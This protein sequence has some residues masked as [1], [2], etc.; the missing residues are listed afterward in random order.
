VGQLARPFVWIITDYKQAP[1]KRQQK[2]SHWA[3]GQAIDTAFQNGHFEL[4]HASLVAAH[5]TGHHKRNRWISVPTAA[6]E[7]VRA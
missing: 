6:G 7:P 3:G 5:A 2:R 1:L 4:L